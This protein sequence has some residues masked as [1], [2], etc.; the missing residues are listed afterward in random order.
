MSI[1]HNFKTTFENC[2]SY[3]AKLN[4][5][6]WS[7]IQAIWPRWTKLTVKIFKS[8]L[9]CNLQHWQLRQ[10][11]FHYWSQYLSAGFWT[12]GRGIRRHRWIHWA[13]SYGRLSWLNLNFVSHFHS[14]DE[15]LTKNEG[16]WSAV[17]PDWTIYFQLGDIFKHVIRVFAKK[18][19]TLGT[20]LKRGQNLSFFLWKLP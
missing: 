4:S 9:N 7:N 1:W 17:W 19:V 10:D 5:F 16:A 12:C 15:D 14:K 6:K 11:D 20:F 18:I 2:L 8:C 3:W 13:S